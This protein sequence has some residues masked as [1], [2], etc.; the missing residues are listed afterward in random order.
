MKQNSALLAGVPHELVDD[1]LLGRLSQLQTPQQALAVVQ[2]FD[3]KT[4][5]TQEGI[6]LVLETIQDPGNMGTLI[7]TAD[8]FGVKQIVCS[9]D[10]VDVYNPK[11]VQATMGSLVRIPVT[12]MP[13]KGW[14]AAQH[15]VRKWAAVL[16]GS[17]YRLA[18]GD[19]ILMMGNESKGLSAELS[20]MATAQLTIPRI[21]GAESLNVAVATGVLLAQ[22]T[23]G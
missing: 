15:S 10:C 13:L 3:W 22:L 18:D 5:S 21:G 14:I 11:V 16:S 7:R 1:I 12:Y 6:H 4:I 17:D 9:P 23:R 2:Q 8:W 20:A 19:G